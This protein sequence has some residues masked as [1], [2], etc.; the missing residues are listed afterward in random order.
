ML[1]AN[2]DYVVQIGIKGE[3]RIEGV[4]QFIQDFPLDKLISV[5]NDCDRWCAVDS[6]L[7]HFCATMRLKS[8]VVIWSR[9]SPRVWGYPHN[10]N[11]L[12]D[13]SYLREYQYA[14]WWDCE[15]DENAFVEPDVVM[16]ALHGRLSQVAT[17]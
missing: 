11:L 1:N 16:D 14:H 15:Y 3:E 7:P 9:S 8:G 5:I 6:F 4:A 12:K 17:A 13:K 10:I 2:G